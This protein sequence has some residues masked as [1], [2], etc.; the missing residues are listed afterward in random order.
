[1]STALSAPTISSRATTACFVMGSVALPAEVQTAV[2]RTFLFL[3]LTP[4]LPSILTIN[5]L[6]TYLLAK[7]TTTNSPPPSLKDS[8][9]A[10]VTYS[11][12]ST[13]LSN[14]PDVSSGGTSFSSIDF[15]T[16][17]SREPLAFA[18]STFGTATPLASTNL[19]LFQNEL[20]TYLATEAGIRSVGGNL[21][22]KAP[23]FFLSFQISR[24][25]S[26]QGMFPPPPPPLLG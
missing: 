4:I 17:S 2:V 1:M 11:T 7:T 26:A 21:A 24:I 16:S 20:N 3:F 19:T 5:H 6:P 14:V 15:S 22:I 9:Q 18:L 13:T 23:K 10:S 12:S 8:I 25:L